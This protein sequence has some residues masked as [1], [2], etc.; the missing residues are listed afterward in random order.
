MLRSR[1][2]QT[3]KLRNQFFF[4][5]S[6]WLGLKDSK[7]ILANLKLESSLKKKVDS[8]AFWDFFGKLG[9][10]GHHMRCQRRRRTVV[11]GNRLKF[12]MVSGF[13]T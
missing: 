6:I 10:F 11:F 8:R 3:I 1:V 9:D 5:V 7:G 2:D 13:L 12:L 4:G